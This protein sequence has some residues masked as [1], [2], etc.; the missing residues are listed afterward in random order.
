MGK[1]LLTHRR[2]HDSMTANAAAVLQRVW[3]ARQRQRQR[4]LERQEE[5]GVEGFFV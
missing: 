4:Q 2:M 1:Q 3:R 5:A